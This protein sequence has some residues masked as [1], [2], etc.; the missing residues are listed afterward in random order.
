MT[1]HDRY[2]GCDVS[3]HWL[4]VFDPVEGKA[5]RIENT[6][7]QTRQLAASL[8]ATRAFVV[9]EATGVYD[10]DLRTALHAAG[11]AS[12]RINPTM[13]RRYAQ[14]LGRKAKTDALDAA[15]LADLGTRLRP[16]PDPAPCPYRARLAQLTLRRDQLVAA[17]KDETIR[18]RAAREAW[19]I[20]SLKA[21]IAWL[22]QAVADVDH[23]INALVAEHDVLQA[24]AQVLA[25]APGVGPVTAQVLLALMP[26]L[27]PNAWPPLPGWLRS[28]MTP[29]SSKAGA[30]SQADDDVYA[31]PCSSLPCTPRANALT[32]KPSQSAYRPKEN[33][34]N[35][36]SSPS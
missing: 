16:E 33:P 3:K 17:R 24:Q 8:A 9:F 35:S 12:A 30:A 26:E 6:P 11:V 19:M 25:S 31:L 36:P 27:V 28:T 4:D 2:V 32:S 5:R 29:V 1:L 20:E 22:D 14:A 34:E 15:V 10:L 13:A 18:L 21:H 23:K 7:A